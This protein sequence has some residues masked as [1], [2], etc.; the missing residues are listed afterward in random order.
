M[1]VG[2]FA[3]SP[4]GSLHLGNLRT[5]LLAWCFA[6]HEQGRFL[7]RVE[8]LTTGAL[9]VAEAEQLADL[10]TLGLTHDGPV[11]RQSELR[12]RHDAAIALLQER[13][14]T[15]PCHCT[16]REIREASQAPHGEAP[17]GAYPGTCRTLGPSERERRDA[18]GR[19]AALRLRAEGVTIQV[20]DEQ[21]GTIRAAV[22]DL[23]L[24][25]ADGVASYNLAV[26]VDDAAQGVDQVVRGADLLP[27]TPRQVL[28]QRLL[29]LATPRY[30]HV[31]LVLGVDGARLAKRHGAV[32]LAD[33][34]AAGASP[35]QVVGLLAGS[36]GLASPGEA[37]TAEQ[38]LARFDPASLPREPWVLDPAEVDAW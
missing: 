9:P 17:E 24:R 4:S 12:G 36:L 28:L 23:V 33:Q 37:L 11:E 27:T 14:L 13:G 32:G 38:V 29:G 8:D 19:P 31:P 16:R 26:V 30:V 20:E 1:T 35:A 2:R 25:R 10:A 5:A 7:L 34:L 21:L 18:A 6:R 3:P 15:Y 22:D